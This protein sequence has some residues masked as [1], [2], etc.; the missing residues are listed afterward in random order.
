LLMVLSAPLL[1]AF[2][3]AVR[4]SFLALPGAR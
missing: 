3:A 1:M 2:E 4:A